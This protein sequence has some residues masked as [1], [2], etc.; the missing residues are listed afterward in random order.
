MGA[1]S[2]GRRDSELEVLP[3]GRRTVT[4]RQ[5]GSGAGPDAAPGGGSLS[6]DSPGAGSGRGG[7]GESVSQPGRADTSAFSMG[8]GVRGPRDIDPERA[9]DILSRENAPT[10]GNLLG[11][12]PR[13]TTAQKIAGYV[14]SLI[15]GLAP[16]PG[17][18]TLL[19]TG[20][21]AATRAG[22]RNMEGM[23][24]A[25]IAALPS[26]GSAQTPGEVGPIDPLTAAIQAS[27]RP[28]GDP[29][30]QQFQ[31]ALRRARPVAGR[32]G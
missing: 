29:R 12:G 11:L 2:V 28:Q 23:T 14:G 7:G 32:R 10:L 25:E 21:V 18:G 20:L 22:E 16:V 1:D 4:A 31:A 6:G 24:T 13:E 5:E 15:G 17:A 27:L 3:G 8:F 9:A 26:F 19:G 30:L